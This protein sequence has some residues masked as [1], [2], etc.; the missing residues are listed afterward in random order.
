M[1]IKSG[2]ATL[3]ASYSRMAPGNSGQSIWLDDVASFKDGLILQR[4]TQ[5]PTRLDALL[6]ITLASGLRVT[7]MKFDFSLQA[8]S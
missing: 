5:D 4:N 1:T 7:A 6:P 8:A 3:V 2:K